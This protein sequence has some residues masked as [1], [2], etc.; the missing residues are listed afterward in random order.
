M[1]FKTTYKMIYLCFMFKFNKI[2]MVLHKASREF[3]LCKIKG[4][5]FSN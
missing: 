4:D 5:A 3:V 1:C 2:E